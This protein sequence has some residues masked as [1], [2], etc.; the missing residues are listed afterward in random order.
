M[1]TNKLK[2]W[3]LALLVGLGACSEDFLE[4]EV[5]TSKNIATSIN[6]LADL[7][8]LVLGAYDRMNHV[9]YYGR[10]YVIFGDVRSDNAFSTGN[11][12]RFIQPADFFVQTTDAYPR[13]TWQQLY[14]V[15][16]NANIVI[17]AEVENNESDAVKHVKGQ[18]YAI[19]ALAYMD[20]VKL[21]GQQFVA[22]SD[23]GVPLVTEFND[24]NLYPERASVQASYAQIEKDL[25]AAALNM[26][27]ELDEASRT[28]ITTSVVP[29]IQSRFYLFTKEYDK[30]AAAAKKVIDSGKYSLLSGDAYVNS[31]LEGGGG[32]AIFE[33]A[34]SNTDNLGSN[35]LNYI[36][37]P[38]NYGDVQVTT[39]L[40]NTYE[41]DDVRKNLY[42]VDGEVIRMVGKYSQYWTNVPVIRYAEVVLNYAEALV[43]DN[44]SVA[45]T[46]LN[47]IAENRGA[48]LYSEATVDNVLEER[49]KELAFEGHRFYDLMRYERTIPHVDSRQTF[50]AAGIAF[51]NTDLAFPIPESE[52]RANSNVAQNLGYRE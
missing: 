15:I 37:F 39:D 33:L 27:P 22:G 30:A 46:Y 41:D 17:N 21:Y 32:N 42:S 48:S 11:S 9:A 31:W 12:G 47:M 23:L 45:L 36:L 10:D 6:T 29:A 28:V 26:K 50:D 13:D 4:P 43:Q 52:I 34:Y 25:E 51:G 8:T 24:G 7:E 3:A 1:T 44:P 14:R 20:L 40:Y 38:T 16:A 19:R 5:S 49:R 18:A 2:V 35:S